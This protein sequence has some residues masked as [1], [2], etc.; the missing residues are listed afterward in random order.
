MEQNNTHPYIHKPYRNHLSAFSNIAVRSRTRLSTVGWMGLGQANI[1]IYI[2]VV[3]VRVQYSVRVF[4]ELNIS[5]TA[6]VSFSGKAENWLFN[7]AWNE[8][9]VELQKVVL[10]LLASEPCPSDWDTNM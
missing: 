5:K 4:Y 9:T 8:R 6:E 10:Q 2:D 1:R 7:I 3:D